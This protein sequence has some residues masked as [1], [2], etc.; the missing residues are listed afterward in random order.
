ME[1]ISPDIGSDFQISRSLPDSGILG[2]NSAGSRFTPDAKNIINAV[3]DIKH[4][5]KKITLV[6]IFKSWIKTSYLM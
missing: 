1:N 2:T 3:L 4:F 5:P 6:C